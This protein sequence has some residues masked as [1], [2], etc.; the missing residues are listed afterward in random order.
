[1]RKRTIKKQIWIDVYEDNLLKKKAKESGLSESEF[2]RSL[3]KG[4]RIKAQPTEEI[5]I[6]QRELYGIANNINQIARA[7]NSRYG[8]SHDDYKYILNT[9][10]DFILRFE[11][12]LYSRQRWR[13]GN[14]AITKYKV[15]NKN[16]EAVINYVKNGDKTEKGVLVSS[17]NCLPD[18]AYFQMMLT[19]KNFHKEDG[20][21]GY[22]IIQSF[23]GKEVSPE[24]C[25]IIG[26]EFAQN[27]FGD[28]YQVLVCTHIDKENIHNHIV[29]NSVSFVDG[30]KYHNSNAELAFIWEIN[31]DL[32]RKYR[33]SVIESK[34]ANKEIDIARSRTNNYNRNSGKMELI[35]TDIDESINNAKKYQDFIDNLAYKCYYVKKSNNVISIFTPYFNRN[36]RITR[37]FR[38]DYTFENIKN[39]IN[40]RNYQL[41]EN[42]VYKVRMYE[43]LKIKSELLKTSSFYRLY[44]HF[45]YVLGKLPP[46][47]HYEE[48]TPEYYKEIDKFNK[49]CDELDM[50]S[51]YSLISITDVKNLKTK[52]LEEISPLKA[53]KEDYIN[54]YNQTKNNFDKMILKAKINHL[55]EDIE[56]INKKLQICRRIINNAERGAREEKLIEKRTEENREKAEKEVTKNKNKRRLR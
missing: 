12:E 51:D 4:Y 26:V 39:R 11:K 44:V 45:L 21:L 27:L 7:S 16:L 2:I 36:I 14:M 37:A 18:T 53:K 1:M 52:Y 17:I 24:K 23:D 13:G 6:F 43:G 32:C 28:K 29:L 30:L 19:K 46:K 50:I 48:R 8:T 33:L 47:I 55:N 38:E 34:K 3:I 35:K 54:L 5:K 9:L 31:D 25:N 49:L 20:R 56:R 41:K 22:H 42:K 10:S 15:I 40:S